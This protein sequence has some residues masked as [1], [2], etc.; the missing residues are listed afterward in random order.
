MT[1]RKYIPIWLERHSHIS[2]EYRHFRERYLVD[3]RIQD[4]VDREISERIDRI[5]SDG[6]QLNDEDK[7]LFTSGVLKHIDNTDDSRL[8]LYRFKRCQQ[9]YCCR[10]ANNPN[11]DFRNTIND[12]P[13]I[14]VD[15]ATLA[16]KIP[17][18]SNYDR[19]FQ[20]TRPSRYQSCR[21]CAWGD[22]DMCICDRYSNSSYW[23]RR[24][25]YGNTSSTGYTYNIEESAEYDLVECRHKEMRS[26]RRAKSIRLD[27][28][29]YARKQSRKL[30][31]KQSS[32]Y[33]KKMAS[34]SAK[35]HS[36]A[37]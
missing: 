30:A 1:Y 4:I 6:Q 21:Y 34:K 31:K 24:G 32:K 37:V 5:L 33:A 3:L 22:F 28:L 8:K 36:P 29:A 11:S 35:K 25:R 26:Y 13:Y 16:E 15:N 14:L 17:K 10:L 19:S 9:S 23:Y 20:A 7:K 27:R 18:M 2:T 12:L